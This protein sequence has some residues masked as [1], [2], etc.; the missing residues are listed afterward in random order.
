MTQLRIGVVDVFVLRHGPAGLETL[1][2]Q[3]SK[4]GRCPGA[5]E[6]IHG[7][8]EEGERP[9]HA[10]VR[11]LREEVGITPDRLYNVRSHAFYLHASGTVQLAVVFAAM[12]SR[13]AVAR[14][15]EEHAADDWLP[16][17]EALARLSWPSERESLQQLQLLLAGGDAG[18][19][20]D[21]LRV[22]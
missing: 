13:T 5:W 20:E 10:A 14:L 21:V 1:V 2:L 17:A 19:L 7:R 3:R 12:V 11:E 6:T 22:S 15:S 18:A 4:A 9:E 16:V 8:I